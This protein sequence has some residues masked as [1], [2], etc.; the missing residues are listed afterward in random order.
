MNKSLFAKPICVR[1]LARAL[2]KGLSPLCVKQFITFLIALAAMTVSTTSAWG[3]TKSIKYLTYNGSTIVEPNSSPVN[4]EPITSTSYDLSGWYYVEGNVTIE[5]TLSIFGDTH[6]ILC[7]DS[8][9]KI[10]SSESRGFLIWDGNLTIYAQS[11][12]SHAGKLTINCFDDVLAPV[13]NVTINGGNISATSSDFNGITCTKFT[14]NG[15]EVDIVASPYGSTGIRTVGGFIITGGTLST[16]GSSYGIVTASGKDVTING[17]KV[18]ATGGTAGISSGGAI[19]LGW[20]NAEDYIEASSYDKL[21]TAVGTKQFNIEGGGAC[22]YEI[23]FDIE[24]LKG[25]KLTPKT[26]DPIYTVSLGDGVSAD[27]VEFDKAKAF[28]GER[29]AITVTPPTGQILTSLTYSDGSNTYTISTNSTDIKRQANDYVITMPAANVTVNATFNPYLAQIG[30]TQYATLAEALAAVA[31]GETIV[32]LDDITNE[33]T[34]DY[35]AGST[36]KDVTIDLKGHDVTFGEIHK[37]GE[38]NITSTETGGKFTASI[39]DNDGNFTVSNATLVCTNSLVTIRSVTFTNS[40][41]T[42][43]SLN[44]GNNSDLLTLTNSTVTVTSSMQWFSD[45]VKVENHSNFILNNSTFFVGDG[46]HTMSLDIDETSNIQ[47]VECTITGYGELRDALLNYVQP[48]QEN[49]LH[50]SD[51]TYSDGAK[52]NIELK[53]RAHTVT[54]NSGTAWIGPTESPTQ[55]TSTTEVRCNSTVTIVASDVS[56]KQFSHWSTSSTG[57]TFASSTAS[58]TTFTMPDNAVTVTANYTEGLLLVNNLSNATVQFYNGGTTAPTASTFD[59]ANYVPAGESGANEIYAIDNSDGQDHYVIM[60]IVPHEGTLGNPDDPDYWTNER[61]LSVLD[62]PATASETAQPLMLRADEYDANL[63]TPPADMKARHNGAGWY[64]Y[65]LPAAHSVANGYTNSTLQG[66]TAPVFDMETVSLTQNLETGVVTLSRTTDTWTAELTY[67]RLHWPFTGTIDDTDKPKLKKI[68][69]KYGGSPLITLDST[70]A[71]ESASDVAQAAAAAAEIAAQ[72]RHNY[73]YPVSQ[74]EWNQQQIGNA[75]AYGWFQGTN[76]STDSYFWI[77][78][79]FTPLDPTEATYP[80]GTANN[81]WLIQSGADLSM[82]AKC[83]NIGGWTAHDRYLRQSEDI[84]LAAE[85]VTD[86]EPIASTGVVG[87]GFRGHYDGF[88]KTI[89]HIDYECT[90]LPDIDGTKCFVGLFGHLFG[91]DDRPGWV[92]NVTLKDCEFKAAAGS[93]A[94]AV[95]TIAGYLAGHSASAMTISNCKVLGSTEVSGLPANCG[96]GAIIGH[97]DFAEAS[98]N[99]LANNYY[100]YGVTVTNAVG[101]ATGYTP[102]GYSHGLVYDADA[103]AWTYE[104]LDVT[105]NDGAVL[106][107]KKASLGTI[108]KPTGST[109]TIAFSQTTTPALAD[110]THPADCYSISGTDYYY[111]VDQPVTLSVTTGSASPDGVRTFYDELDELSVSY[112][113]SPP[114]TTPPVTTTDDITTT[115]SFA[116][117]VADAA[118]AATFTSSD[119]FTINTVNYNATDPTA[120]F[121]YNWMTF[122]HEWT[123]KDPTSG[124]D[125]AGKFVVTNYDNPAAAVEVKTITAVDPTAGTYTPAAINGCYSGVPTLFHY[126]D[127]SGGVLPQKLKFTPDFNI[128]QNQTVDRHFKG[129]A[130]ART[131]SASDKCYIL[132]NAGDFI[133]AYVTPTDNTIAAHRCYVDLSGDNSNQARLISS[134]DA[135]GIDSMVNGQGTMD[136]LD[137]DWFS[138][139]GRR[140]NGQPKR[141]GI[142]IHNGKKTVIK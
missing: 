73:P 106:L 23:G 39:I 126:A 2:Q 14:L 35:S 55:V 120:P 122:Y 131:L 20:T 127:N 96:T 30:D 50:V 89:S 76:Y 141:K 34:S 61:L 53:K 93:C 26:D 114:G 74:L 78:V 22:G 8:E 81:P 134:G 68:V 33:S 36:N 105:D 64:Y 9:L 48:G 97:C 82:L 85:G 123:M 135:T 117:P 24:S 56:G 133:L 138:L 38:L 28:A 54:V 6:L 1:R 21:P 140:L 43:Y 119:W 102:R 125:V 124:N 83:V 142:Y 79:P 129:T 90:R 75:D 10:N 67:D 136:N 121:A 128:E 25:K 113:T 98:N 12:G 7:D 118:I 59:P 70:P 130:T 92:K 115:L 60:H 84:D 15:G 41:A 107:V 31:D 11:S 139:D 95:G 32:I 46:S 19:N 57:V 116:M 94:V 58:T 17:G 62:G 103:D 86:F 111:A 80:A 40:T 29:V 77:D 110:A 49:N 112:V 100:G 132:N 51:H 18:S 137:G 37:K 101:T 108:N 104:W 5:G 3:E 42:I 69:M 71:S 91:M 63:G 99:S 44:N 65:I 47:F 27:N 13:G 87:I 72:I 88:G 109:S 4:A 66:L 45:Y 52:N 16:T